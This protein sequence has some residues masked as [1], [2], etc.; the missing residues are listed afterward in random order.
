MA[1][2]LAILVPVLGYSADRLVVRD[3]GGGTAFVVTEEGRVGISS[4]VTLYADILGLNQVAGAAFDIETV[5]GAPPSGAIQAINGQFLIKY[6]PGVP[7]V[8][9][10]N[11]FRMIART[12]GTVTDPLN[13]HLAAGNFLAQHN[14]GGTAGTVVGV[15]T[16]VQLLGTGD[17][18][19][20]IAVRA[21][22]PSRKGTG[23]MSNAYGVNILPQRIT[24]V[25]NGYGVYQEGASDLNY[26]AGNIGVGK[27][28][29]SNPIEAANGASLSAGGQWIDGSSR[30]Y[31]DNIRDLTKEE[32]LSAF[33]GL[34]P[35]AF[36]YKA[37][38]RE[39]HIGFIAE[40]VPELVAMKDRKGLSPIDIVA[41]L[42]KVVQEQNK[43]VDK[44]QAVINTLTEKLA[45]LEAKMEGLQTRETPL[46]IL[47][48]KE[49]FTEAWVTISY[50]LCLY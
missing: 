16:N 22:S 31:K 35:V 30:E 18:T 21:A 47:S 38:A 12:D 13:G 36:T 19:S 20:A 15:I 4:N 26:F 41:V 48:Q 34:N 14:G 24:G 32:A 10:F 11:T 8:N 17:I 27:T 28:N 7:I 50:H 49:S 2:I 23:V 37:G 29:P 33:Q 43:T 44:Q 1:V 40:D 46:S 45:Q 6:T 9:N 25:T 3:N 5:A 42:T 39:Q